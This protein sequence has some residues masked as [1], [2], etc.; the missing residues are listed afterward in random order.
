MLLPDVNVCLLGLRPDGSPAGPLVRAWLEDALNGDERVVVSDLVLS[1][2]IRIATN[3]RVFNEPVTSAQAV[4]YAD[5][6]RSAPAAAP[7]V[8]TAR[9]WGAF[10]ELVREHRLRGNDVPDAWYAAIALDLGATLVTLDRGFRRF[11]QL[12]VL[13]P[14][15]TE[16]L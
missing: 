2:V 10:T 1:A 11:D 13:D 7:A 9:Q 14:S 5:S 8:A 3:P 16:R 12:R 4:E 15:T 6:L